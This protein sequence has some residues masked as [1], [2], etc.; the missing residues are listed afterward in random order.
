[1]EDDDTNSSSSKLGARRL[2]LLL[3]AGTG[4]GATEDDI[5]ESIEFRS[6]LLPLRAGLPVEEADENSTMVGTVA[7]RLEAREDRERFEEAREVFSL[8]TDADATV[9]WAREWLSIPINRSTMLLLVPLVFRLRSLQRSM[10]SGFKC[11][12]SSFR[13]VNSCSIISSAASAAA[14][15]VSSTMDV[16]GSLS[17]FVSSG[18]VSDTTGML[19]F[20]PSSFGSINSFVASAAA[21]G[22]SSTV[23]AAGAASFFVSSGTVSDTTRMPSF[24]PSSFGAI[25]DTMPSSVSST[26]SFFVSQYLATVTKASARRQ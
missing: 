5:S 16:A 2:L 13:L 1:M 26:G 7:V 24:V 18:T 10:S 22:F 14:S 8:R 25:S 19:S 20:V 17:F 15:G 4:V 6:R 23:D 21:S 3:V 9:D 12:M 11:A